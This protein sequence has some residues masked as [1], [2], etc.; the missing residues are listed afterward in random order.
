MKYSTVHVSTAWTRTSI[1]VVVKRAFPMCHILYN[2]LFIC[3]QT[4]L[5]TP[6][7]SEQKDKNIRSIG[8]STNAEKGGGVGGEEIREHNGK[9][10]VK[11]EGDIPS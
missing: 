2:L 11:K 3:I 6:Y 5:I 8:L 4:N 7:G 10:K 9:E 1:I